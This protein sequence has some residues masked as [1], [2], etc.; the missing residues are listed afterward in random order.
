MVA[1]VAK[2]R[3]S[4]GLIARICLTSFANSEEKRVSASSTMTL[5]RAA[6]LT[7]YKGKA[8]VI[9]G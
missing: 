4:A 3:R 9:P 8:P 7:K 1:E 6:V 2:T 5:F